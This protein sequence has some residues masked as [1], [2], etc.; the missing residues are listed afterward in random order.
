MRSALSILVLL[1]MMI[2]APSAWAATTRNDGPGEL[3][4]AGSQPGPAEVRSYRASGT[5]VAGSPGLL[6][7][8]TLLPGPHVDTIGPGQVR[9]YAVE[10]RAGT[11]YLAATM[12]RPLRTQ[13][14]VGDALQTEMLDVNG[15]ACRPP[16][17]ASGPVT[18]VEPLTAVTGTGPVSAAGNG[19]RCSTPGRYYLGVTRTD[20]PT[21]D[22]SAVPLELL[23]VLEPPLAPGTAPSPLP[24]VPLGPVND[25]SSP[26]QVRGSGSFGDATT[27]GSGTYRDAIRPGETVFFR[28]PVGWGQRLQYDVGFS[29]IEP[30]GILNVESTV[31]NPYRG[32]IGVASTF[33]YRDPEVLHLSTPTVDYTNRDDSDP[34][35]TRARLAGYHYIAVRVANDK[36]LVIGDTAVPVNLVVNVLGAAAPSPRYLAGTSAGDPLPWASTTP[37]VAKTTQPG[38]A[39]SVPTL[40]IGLTVGA[41]AAAACAIALGRRYVGARAAQ[42]E[43]R[44]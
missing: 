40:G 27:V 15:K 38:P 35:I 20:G 37:D 28:V 4:G 26:Q 33:I 11:P 12:A 1:L 2:T 43:H 22:P 14:S 31:Y 41:V 29:P 10:A 21:S 42:R 39:S 13:S 16:S 6:T 25:A 8:P 3:P 32:G 34:A 36:D 7:A 44:R 19:D 9:Y 30:N 17:R 23:Y 18:G 5:P 24:E